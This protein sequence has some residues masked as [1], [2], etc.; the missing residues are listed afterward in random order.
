LC[1]GACAG[2]TIAVETPDGPALKGVYVDG[3]VFGAYSFFAS[4]QHILSA[5]ARN[6][7]TQGRVLQLRGCRLPCRMA[8][9]IDTS[10]LDL[11]D[12]RF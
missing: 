10:V 11:I 4:W 12:Y 6:I 7:A 9:M 2:C 5:D 8:T 3:P 1:C